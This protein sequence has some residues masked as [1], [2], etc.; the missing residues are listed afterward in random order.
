MMP[1]SKTLRR[2][3]L[4]FGIWCFLWTPAWSTPTISKISVHTENELIT[5]D[6]E[7]ID[8]FTE[9]ILEAIESGVTMT[10][11]YQIELL[12]KTSVFGDDV[13]SQIQVA[14]TV[15][16]NT[17]KK[18]YEFTSQGKNV[19]RKVSTKSD[20]RY[21]QLM[22]TLKDIPIGHVFK[23]DPEEKYYARVKAEMEADGL[24]FP[25]NYLLFFVPFSEF[26]T[27]WTQSTPVTFHLD[28]AFG[29]EATQKK[30]ESAIPAKGVANG[31]RSFNQ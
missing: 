31:I 8:A 12:K 21:K 5:L 4:L 28:A 9:K 10:F 22:L 25:F 23:L 18:V 13:V 16:Y 11:T 26:E 29:G 17:L 15:Q 30:S 3:I 27:S 14:Q 2:M 1:F 20:E 19:N 7:L 24:W 6:A